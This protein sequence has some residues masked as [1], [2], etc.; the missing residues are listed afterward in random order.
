MTSYEYQVIPAPRKGKKARGVKGSE[1]RF[2]LAIQDALNEASADGW[3]YLRTDT[4][5]SEERSGLTGRTTVYQNL[6]VFRRAIEDQTDEQAADA[7]F[8]AVTALAEVATAEAEA[9]E[10]HHAPNLPS[11][12]DANEASDAAPSVERSEPFTLR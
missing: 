9:A 5:P 8:E 6:L 4:L 7:D 3:E 2:A 11:A 10:E 1:S 12:T